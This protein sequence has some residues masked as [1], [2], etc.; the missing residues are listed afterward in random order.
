MITPHELNIQGLFTRK[1]QYIIPLFQRTY[2]WNYENW[3]KLWSDII[4]LYDHESPQPHFLGVTVVQALDPP[5]ISTPRVLLIDGQQRLTTLSILLTAL[6][7]KAKLTLKNNLA[8]EINS[9]LID[10]HETEDRRLKIIPTKQDQIYFKNLIE[11]NHNNESIQNNLHNAYQFFERKI[12]ENEINLE[13]LKQ[14]ILLYLSIVEITLLGNE[15]PYRIF[16]SLNATGKALTP[17]DLVRNFFFM[18]IPNEEHDK[19]YENYWQPMQETLKEHLTPFMRF[20]LMKDGNSVKESNIYSELKSNIGTNT[21][22]VK[23]KLIELYDFAKHYEKII[24]PDKETNPQIQKYLL[25]H[26]RLGY[27]ATYPFLLNVYQQYTRDYTFKEQFVTVL[28]TLENFL[29]RRFVCNAP[30]NQLSKIFTKLYNDVCRELEQREYKNFSH[31]V[32]VILHSKSYSNDTIFKEQFAALKLIKNTKNDIR[33]LILETLENSYN[34]KEEIDFNNPQITV[35]HIMPQTL[36]NDWKTEIGDNWEAVH[37]QLLDHIGNL[38]LTAYNSELSNKP[39][40]EKKELYQ[41]SHFQ[42]NTYFSAIDKWNEKSITERGKDLA[43]RAAD[44]WLY[45]GPAADRYEKLQ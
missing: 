29:I 17:A 13:K 31:T 10:R 45:F 39:F 30:S 9:L 22:N 20:F 35:E 37:K 28:K 44:I 36:S 11:P 14:I 42:L 15:D 33:K 21:D 43:E 23:N 26:N 41:K 32:Q 12:N 25:R 1:I 3:E 40:N 38:T 27:T 19:F 8:D 7:N 24:N 18:N 2:D 16:E 4:D 34:H 5:T 6:R